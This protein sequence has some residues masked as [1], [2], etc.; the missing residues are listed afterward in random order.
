MKTNVAAS[1]NAS[2]IPTF[3]GGASQT[4]IIPHSRRLAFLFSHL[5][6]AGV[7]SSLKRLARLPIEAQANRELL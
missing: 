4:R 7:R 1:S 3:H 6:C 5:A 2:F